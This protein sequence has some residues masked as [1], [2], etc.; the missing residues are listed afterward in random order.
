LTPNDFE[1]RRK[2]FAAIA[3]GEFLAVLVRAE[4]GR[5]STEARGA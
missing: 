1:A 2:A 3:L 5:A 4:S